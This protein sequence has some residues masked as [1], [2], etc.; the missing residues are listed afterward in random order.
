MFVFTLKSHSIT[1][2]SVSS[3]ESP[4]RNRLFKVFGHASRLYLVVCLCVCVRESV[5]AC[6]QKIPNRFQLSYLKSPTLFKSVQISKP[7][8]LPPVFVCFLLFGSN[9]GL[10]L[11]P[12]SLWVF[13]AC[14]LPLVSLHLHLS[15]SS[16]SDSHS[17]MFLV[18]RLFNLAFIWPW[19]A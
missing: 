8:S 18:F 13:F 9:L 19:F 6:D 1:Q 11:S 15:Q 12:I 10:I 3:L 16:V 14:S 4:L 17:F 5:C 7:W 2:V